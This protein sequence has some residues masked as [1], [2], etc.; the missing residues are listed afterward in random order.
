MKRNLYEVAL[1]ACVGLAASVVHFLVAVGGIEKLSLPAW[2]ANILAF[3]CA[4]PV[5]YFGHALLTFS[6]K[7]YNR[8]TRVS[9]QTLQKFTL[10]AVGGF[11][12]NQLCVI[13]FISWLGLP[14]R[15]VMF[16]IVFG[17]A[18]FLFLASKFW[19]FRG[20]KDAAPAPP[21]TG[22]P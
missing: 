5:S 16:A 6:A 8:A 13:I 10:T 19:A 4:L 17:V 2:Q 12:L 22:N 15:P 1:F 3:L 21:E 11:A 14:H 7:H 9:V 18:G 20:N